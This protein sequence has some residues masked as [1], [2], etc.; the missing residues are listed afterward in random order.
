M[1]KTESVRARVEARVEA[2]LKIEAEAV[3]GALGLTP[4]E[5]ITLF[6][7]QVALHHDLP[8]PARIPNDST[9]AAIRDAL[10]GKNLTEWPDLEALKA[11]HR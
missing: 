5:A 11:A 8:F 9:Q 4:T 7:R 1:P 6:Y 10:T 2:N 3:F